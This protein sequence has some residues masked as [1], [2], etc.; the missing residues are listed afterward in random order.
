MTHRD[1]EPKYNPAYR[2][3]LIAALMVAAGVALI[4]GTLIGLTGS[5]RMAFSF[6][7]AAAFLSA[8]AV[9][10]WPKP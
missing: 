9:A 10:L 3:A 5:L 8:A 4:L 6:F 1:N 2:S 7:S